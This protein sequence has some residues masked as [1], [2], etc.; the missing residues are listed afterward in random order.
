[1]LNPGR[2]AFVAEFVG[3][4]ALIFVGVGSIVADQITKGAVGVT[5]VALAHGL[6]IAV[7]VS[8]T[9][10]I[11]GGHLNPAVTVSLLA[12]R[13]IGAAGALGYIVAQVLGAIAAALLLKACVPGPALEAVHLGTPAAGAGVSAGQVI[14]IEAILTFFLVFVIYGTAVDPR[15]PRLAGLFIG[16]TVGLDVLAG[17]PLTGAAMNPARFLGPALV[18]GRLADTALYIV[19]P[20]AGALVAA[21][22]WRYVLELPAGVPSPGEPGSAGRRR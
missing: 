17:G 4:F 13:K 8:A 19:G 6:T 12:V 15:A 7:M 3:T 11:S 16:L 22:L 5:G 21:L 20:V 10:A 18:S 1:M 9:A 14:L 2:R